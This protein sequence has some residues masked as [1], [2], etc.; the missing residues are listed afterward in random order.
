MRGTLP[1]TVPAAGAGLLSGL[2]AAAPARSQS[3]APA[4]PPAAAATKGAEG[5]AAFLPALPGWTTSEAP[6]RYTP[7]D[8]YEYIDGAADGFLEADFL[9]LVS[10]QYEA[11]GG[12]SLTVD[13]YR[14]ADADSTFGMYSQERPGGGAF[15]PVGA[16]GYYET[17]ILNFWKGDFYVK[18]AAFGLGPKD[19]ETLL[20]A[21]SA[22]ARR[23]PGEARM[24]RLLAALPDRGK[25]VASE[26]Y[27]RRN[28]LGYPF[29]ERAFTAQYRFGEKKVAAFVLTVGGEARAAA[30][31]QE[32]MKAQGRQ[33]APKAGA[34]A[35]IQDPHHGRVTALASGPYLVLLVGEEGP[36]ESALLEEV[37]KGLKGF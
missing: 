36:E 25:V 28:V 11:P 23:L 37:R 21:A 18:L 15:L 10:Q 27:L 9:E 2:L 22:A 34:P 12:R 35:M 20:D 17:G 14:H 7:E 8:L 3:T 19:R 26:R 24:P 16:Q 29:L 31:L 4:S 30:V 33:G 6:R 5:L 32:Y 1:V 13:I